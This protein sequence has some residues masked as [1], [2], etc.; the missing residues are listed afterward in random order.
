MD[1][2]VLE[3]RALHD[4]KMSTQKNFPVE[5]DSSSYIYDKDDFFGD[6]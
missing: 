4:L 3:H 1:D 2:K 5:N 6:F